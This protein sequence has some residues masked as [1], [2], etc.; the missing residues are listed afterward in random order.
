MGRLV[1]TLDGDVPPPSPLQKALG[2][3]LENNLIALLHVDLDG[4]RCSVRYI[5]RGANPA[6]SLVSDLLTQRRDDLRVEGLFDEL[7]KF[8]DCALKI[9]EAYD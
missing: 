3:I 4:T 8:L 2:G 9:P 5:K 7:G 6:Y 1:E